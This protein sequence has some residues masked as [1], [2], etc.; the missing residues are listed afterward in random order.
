MKTRCRCE[1][2]HRDGSLTAWTDRV[3]V[4]RSG[5][6]PQVYSIL[7]EF[8]LAGEMQETSKKQILERI[9]E[10]EKLE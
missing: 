4:R 5:A 2:F 1:A 10:L 8:I 3:V 9:K 7:D 6:P